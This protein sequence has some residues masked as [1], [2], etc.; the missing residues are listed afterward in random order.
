MQFKNKLTGS[1]RSKTI[2]AV[3]LLASTLVIAA[4]TVT[5]ADK[6]NF[7]LIITDDAGYAD[8]G[9]MGSKEM[10]TPNMDK[11]AYDG[12]IFTQAYAG[13]SC[14][15]SRCALLTGRYQQ[16]YGFGRNCGS[17][18]NG[19]NNGLPAGVQTIPMDLKKLGYHT[20]AIGKWH[21]GATA[22]V[23]QPQDV[24]FDEFWGILSGSRP[25]FGEAKGPKAIWRG[26]VPD[27]G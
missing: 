13:P 8:F 2:L 3:A 10:K 18:F 1:I 21:Q 17:S 19:P 11:L 27:P 23:N 26:R 12:V 25:Y 7:I 22:G 16:R 4:Q 20:A 14:S 5:A 15:P 24:D 6:P 9:F